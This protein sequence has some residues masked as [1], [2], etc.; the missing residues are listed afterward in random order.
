MSYKVMVK[1]LND[2]IGNEVPAPKYQTE[3]SAGMDL[4]AAIDEDI[5]IKKG[6]TV[7]VPTGIA[8]ALPDNS[9]VAYIYARSGLSIKHGVMLANGVGVIDS[10][11]RG[12]IKVGLINL[13]KE[14]YV[15]KKGDRIAQMVFAPVLIAETVQVE[16]LPDTD[17][18][19]GGF[20]STGR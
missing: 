4:S 7:L 11:Y 5:L 10:D 1:Y 6:E 12:E 16:E 2:E 3:G 8:I 19:A 20:G 9:S 18:G 14:D 17:R 15:I 13:G